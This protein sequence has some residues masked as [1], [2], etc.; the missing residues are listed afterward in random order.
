MTENSRFADVKRQIKYLTLL[1]KGIDPTT[2]IVF[3]EDTILNNPFIKELL[4]ETVDSLR[5]Y[6]STMHEKRRFKDD[7]SI[8]E[9]QIKTLEPVDYPITIS[10]IAGSINGKKSSD[11]KNLE[12]T[13][14][15][16]W[17]ELKGYLTTEQNENGDF[18][19]VPTEKG[20]ELG[21]TRNIKVRLDGGTYSANLYSTEAQRF[22][23]EHLL[24]VLQDESVL[25]AY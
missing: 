22:V 10:R 5:A 20:E 9:E 11:V 6:S 3:E 16:K 1:T 17:L 8:T 7:F 21:I 15:T 14:L 2:N 13:R 18:W 19:K 4:K 25:C 23:Y 24:D 12:A